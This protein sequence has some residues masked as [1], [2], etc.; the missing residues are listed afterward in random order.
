MEEASA[1]Q[2]ATRSEIALNANARSAQVLRRFRYSE[3]QRPSLSVLLRQ[4]E[5]FFH[6]SETLHFFMHN[7][8][9][10]I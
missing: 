4:V 3:K 6:F 10:I 8:E 5:D 7:E 2:A 9:T 1:H